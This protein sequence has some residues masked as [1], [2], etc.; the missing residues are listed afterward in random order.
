MKENVLIKSIKYLMFTHLCETNDASH[1][2]RV[3][4]AKPST[5][6]WVVEELLLLFGDISL[7]SLPFK[8]NWWIYPFK[9][10]H[11]RDSKRIGESILS[12]FSMTG[13]HRESICAQ[14][15]GLQQQQHK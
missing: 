12:N 2:I 5:S 3:A 6:S 7:P 15:T 9:L 11:D 1:V 10:W 8:K 13:T 4:V 14:E